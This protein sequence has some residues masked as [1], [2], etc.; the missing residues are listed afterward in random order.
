MRY[1]FYLFFLSFL[2]VFDELPNY[3][4]LEDSYQDCIPLS[5][6]ENLMNKKRCDLYT[7]R[8]KFYT[9]SVS[10]EYLKSFPKVKF[11]VSFWAINQNDG[12]SDNR[13]TKRKA[14][15]SIRL[16]NKSFKGMNVRFKL[17]NFKNIDDSD[18]YWT[19]LS[20]FYS[21]AKQSSQYVDTLSINVYVPYK[22]TNFKNGLRGAQVNKR[23]VAVNSNEYNTGILVHEIGHIFDLKHTHKSFNGTNCERVT[24]IANDENYNADCAGDY[25]IDT[26]AMRELNNKTQF[27]SEDCNYMADHKDCEGTPYQL[28]DDEIRNFMSYTLQHCRDRFTTGQS[29][30]VREFIANDPFEVVKTFIK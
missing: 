13:F 26:G 14:R 27:I 18:Y 7:K 17:K 8:F 28:G 23:S 21:L 20:K 6:E 12:T 5:F 11:Y 1:K 4:L 15:E 10:E 2:P 29:I 3:N 25:V 9:Q 22:F 19:S 16:L 30:K 24:R